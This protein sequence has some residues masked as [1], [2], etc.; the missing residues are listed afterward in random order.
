MPTATPEIHFG[1]KKHD[2]PNCFTVEFVDVIATFLSLVDGCVDAKIKKT[3]KIS[4]L[5]PLNI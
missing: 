5:C 3:A 4:Q 2:L 1:V